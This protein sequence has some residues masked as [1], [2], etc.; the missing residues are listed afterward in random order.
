MQ[1]RIVS[2][3]E[4]VSWKKVSEVIKEFNLDLISIERVLFLRLYGHLIKDKKKFTKE[5]FKYMK[6]GQEWKALEKFDSLEKL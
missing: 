3:L 2:D 5:I 6:Y 1:K 4:L